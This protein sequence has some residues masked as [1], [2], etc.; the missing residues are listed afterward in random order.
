[1]PNERLDM[2]NGGRYDQGVR[3]GEV[4]LARQRARQVMGQAE[5]IEMLMATVDALGKVQPLATDYSD[6]SPAREA[7]IAARVAMARLDTALV[8]RMYCG[9]AR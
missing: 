2:P 6:G 5:L 4:R 1:M 3:V 8:G 7:G 9:G